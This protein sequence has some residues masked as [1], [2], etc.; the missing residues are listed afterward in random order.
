M[1]HYLTDLKSNFSGFAALATLWNAAA[2]IEQSKLE[3]DFS[4]CQ[5]FDANMSAALAA[6]LARVADRFNGIEIVKVRPAT[7]SILRRNGFLTQF[8]YLPDNGTTHTAIPFRR[9]RHNDA[10]RF[11]DHL[12][13]H[14]AGSKGI[15]EMTAGFG[16]QFK[17]SLFEIF[18]NAR[19]H[20]RSRLG[21]FVCGQFFPTGQRLDILI[22]DAGVGIPQNV[23]DFLETEISDEDALAWALRSGN[24]TKRGAL[25]GGV[26]LKFLK[27]FVVRNGGALD[28][29]SGRAHYRYAAGRETFRALPGIFPGTAVNVE[30]DT[31]DT[32][33]Y[34]LDGEVSPESIF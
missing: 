33:S 5:W 10:G 22:A 12:S 31:R 16:R 32:Q 15:P 23:Q 27:D 30:I 4:R 9:L 13:E 21:T 2:P 19:H 34:A 20:S 14:L 1:I 3:L 26:G 25:P 17:M 7:E 28:I 18:E 8:G 11:E 29:A 24:T 6:V